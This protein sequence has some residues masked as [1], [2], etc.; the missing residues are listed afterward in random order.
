MFNNTEK[1]QHMLLFTK[2]HETNC[3]NIYRRE[4]RCI[5]AQLSYLMLP[6]RSQDLF[7]GRK[8][9]LPIGFCPQSS[10]GSVGYYCDVSTLKD[11]KN[12]TFLS[13]SQLDTIDYLI[14]Y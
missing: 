3:D 7:A 5:Q 10:Y 14:D 2:T 12:D 11:M 8:T 1:L 9:E 6:I 4:A 13:Q